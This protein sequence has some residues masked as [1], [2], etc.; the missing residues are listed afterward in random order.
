MA[1]QI[2]HLCRDRAALSLTSFV[3]W[4]QGEV[5]VVG[6]HTKLQGVVLSFGEET[7]AVNVDDDAP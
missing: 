4:E 3:V 2:F 6:S 5:E 1:R 7:W